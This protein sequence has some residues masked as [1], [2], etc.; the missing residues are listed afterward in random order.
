MPGAWDWGASLAGVL[1]EVWSGAC[2]SVVSN[3]CRT[4]LSGTQGAPLL[5]EKNCQLS[6]HSF[7]VCWW[8][9]DD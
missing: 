3:A 7:G 4:V 1:G 9:A 5:A 2:G 6:E 8:A